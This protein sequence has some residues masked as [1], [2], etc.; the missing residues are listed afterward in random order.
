[1]MMKMMTTMT[2]LMTMMTTAAFEDCSQTFDA[3]TRFA[4]AHTS[5]QQHRRSH[6]TTH[7]HYCSPC[8]QLYS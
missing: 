6:S 4:G 2:M 8:H 3:S 5:T 7:P 1:M